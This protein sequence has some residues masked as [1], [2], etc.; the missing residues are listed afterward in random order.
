VEPYVHS[1]YAIRVWGLNNALGNMLS[2]GSKTTY[3]FRY[4][5]KFTFTLLLNEKIYRHNLY[6]NATCVDNF[7]LTLVTPFCSAVA[8]P[9]CRS[10]SLATQTSPG[11]PHRKAARKIKAVR[12]GGGGQGG[13]FCVIIR[14]HRTVHVT[15]TRI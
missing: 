14:K 7:Q 2:V 9:F 11:A 12:S 6:K 1:P 3:I 15:G 8:T 13:G 4:R 5:D 10:L